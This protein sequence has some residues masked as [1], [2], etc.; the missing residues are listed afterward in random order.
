L[1]THAAFDAEGFTERDVWASARRLIRRS[2]VEAPAKAQALARDEAAAGDRTAQF[3]WI[4][5][6]KASEW[7]LG[8]ARRAQKT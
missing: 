7:I 2:G 3:N 5:V 4:R 8:E 1:S 6:A